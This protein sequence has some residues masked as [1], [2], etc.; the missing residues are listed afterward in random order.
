M[1]GY[2]LISDLLL[3]IYERI[4]INDSVFE[5]TLIG[6]DNILEGARILKALIINPYLQSFVEHLEEIIIA[7]SDNFLATPYTNTGTGEIIDFDNGSLIGR[8]RNFYFSDINIGFASSLSFFDNGKFSDYAETDK[9][10][11]WKQLENFIER[12]LEAQNDSLLVELFLIIENCDKTKGILINKTGLIADNKRNYSYIYLYALNFEGKLSL[13]N[14]LK[15]TNRIIDGSL[16][17]NPSTTYEQYIDVLDVMNE[18][19]HTSDIVSR[20]LKIYHVLEYLTYRITLSE[21]VTNV[22][23]SKSFIRKIIQ[24]SDSIK[25]SEREVFIANFKKLFNGNELVFEARI[26]PILTADNK[27]DIKELY[28]DVAYNPKTLKHNAELIYGIRCSIVHNK[29]SELHIT[30]SN[31]DEYRRLIPVI[32]MLIEVLEELII[33]KISINEPLIQYTKSQLDLY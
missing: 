9:L 2:N 19:N 7:N 6:D 25:K 10:L 22:N 12:V 26:N 32:K 31:P 15:S 3:K 24:L 28:L 14:E 8:N 1:E 21:I 20:Y 29:E 16:N 27:R 30:I 11:L 17:L 4:A 33:A 23:Q 13:D 18:V 5:E